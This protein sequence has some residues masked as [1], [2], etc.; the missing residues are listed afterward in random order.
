MILGN[1]SK[2]VDGEQVWGKFL[3]TLFEGVE[4]LR[5]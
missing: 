3:E 5:H 1:R 2:I 4:T